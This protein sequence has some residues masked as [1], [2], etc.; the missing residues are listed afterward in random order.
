L[1]SNYTETGPARLAKIENKVSQWHQAWVEACQDT[2]FRWDPRWVKK[3]KNIDVGDIVWLVQDS[4]LCRRLKWAIVKSVHPDHDG[5]VR[6]AVVRYALFKPGPESYVTGFNKNGPFRTKLVAV[7]NLAMM[8]SKEEQRKYKEKFSNI[9]PGGSAE[10]SW[11]ASQV[12]VISAEKQDPRVDDTTLMDTLETGAATASQFTGHQKVTHVV[13]HEGNGAAPHFTRKHEQRRAEKHRVRGGF[14][15]ITVYRTIV[16][17]TQSGRDLDHIILTGDNRYKQTLLGPIMTLCTNL[18]GQT[19]QRSLRLSKGK[20]RSQ[21]RKT[22]GPSCLSLRRHTDV[23]SQT[24]VGSFSLRK[25]QTNLQTEVDG[26]MIEDLGTAGSIK[27]KT[28]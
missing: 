14:T 1:K 7:Q 20:M 3:S 2:C 27:L 16:E 23:D 13:S 8:Y 12:Q 28:D 4:K 19:P 18:P 10:V 25:T 17:C 22:T 15:G 24:T 21:P 9:K 5:V 6:D 11:D 26:E